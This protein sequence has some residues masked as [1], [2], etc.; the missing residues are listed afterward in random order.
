M[1]GW[2]KELPGELKNPDLWTAC[3]KI[4]IQVSGR[5]LA[6]VLVKNGPGWIL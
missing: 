5:G 2:L 3:L 4:L 6:I 1:L